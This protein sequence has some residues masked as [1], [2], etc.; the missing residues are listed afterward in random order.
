MLFVRLFDLRACLVLTVSSSSWCLGR[1]AAC[2][3][4]TPW[5]VLLPILRHEEKV[6]LTW[7][8]ICLPS[9]KWLLVNLRKV[10]CGKIRFK[11]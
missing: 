2:D 10:Y 4:G 8:Y 5:T 6:N 11:L 7:T 1:A 3:C 9:H